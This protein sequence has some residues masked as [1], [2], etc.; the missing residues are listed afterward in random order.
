MYYWNHLSTPFPPLSV[1]VCHQCT[2]IWKYSKHSYLSVFSTLSVQTMI[3]VFATQCH[4][5]SAAAV[6]G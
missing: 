2:K 4:T 6:H 5:Y 3:V 1:H